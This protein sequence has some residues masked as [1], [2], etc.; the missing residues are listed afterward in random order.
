[1]YEDIIVKWEPKLHKMLQ[2]CPVYGI[3]QEEILQEMRATIIK[4][5]KH[6]DESRGVKFHT[7]LHKA[8]LN[9]LLILRST[10]HLNLGYAYLK[11]EDSFSDKQD[12]WSF[13]QEAKLTNPEIIVLDLVMCGYK[14][15]ELY[16][17]TDDLINMKKVYNSLKRK[18]AASRHEKEIRV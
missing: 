5:I 1:M 9:T 3:D 15:N 16:R 11:H 17:M 2:T 8:L 13:I 6:F 10:A 14:R 4:A 18:M 7:Y 12:D